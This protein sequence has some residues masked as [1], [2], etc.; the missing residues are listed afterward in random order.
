MQFSRCRINIVQPQQSEALKNSWCLCWYYVSSSAASSNEGQNHI[1][2]LPS[3]SYY[4][5]KFIGSNTYAH[6]CWSNT[7]K[8]IMH[9]ILKLDSFLSHHVI[10]LFV[11]FPFFFITLFL[12]FLISSLPS[13]VK[14]LWPLRFSFKHTAKTENRTI[15]IKSASY[16]IIQ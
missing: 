3:L 5:E 12:L 11:D 2:L 15:Q 13:L 6:Y 4:S 16:N 14:L 8:A 1:L 7:S 9:I 10:L